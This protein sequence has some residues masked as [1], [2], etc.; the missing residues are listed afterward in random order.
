MMLK[1]GDLVLVSNEAR[2]KFDAWYKGPFQVVSSNG[3]NCVVK[4][5]KGKLVEVHKNRVKIFHENTINK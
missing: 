1:P 5:E 2:Q 3:V 4:N